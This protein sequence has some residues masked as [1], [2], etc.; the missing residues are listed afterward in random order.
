M[1]A[2]K[3][4]LPAHLHAAYDWT[5][6]AGELDELRRLT[7]DELLT[8]CRESAENSEEHVPDPSGAITAYELEQLHD[9]LNEG[10]PQ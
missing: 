5:A 1:A 10:V 6:A 3:T 4:P 7:G 9:W 8:Y 2:A